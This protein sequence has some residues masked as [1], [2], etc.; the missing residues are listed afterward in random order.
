MQRL[1]LAEPAG[2]GLPTF[3]FSDMHEHQLTV[4]AFVPGVGV[5]EDPITGSA[6]ALT[7]AMLAA[8]GRLPGR[9]GR[10]VANQG[11]ELA[12][13]GRVERLVTGQKCGSA[14]SYKR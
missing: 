12:R 13:D 6:N 8:Q 2:D 1:G 11:R 5:A 7:A 10:C 3:A 4:R 14:A 9:G